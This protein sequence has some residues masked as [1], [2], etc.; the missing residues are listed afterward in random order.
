MH[1]VQDGPEACLD[2]RRAFEVS[3]AFHSRDDVQV[4]KAM[5]ATPTAVK[6]YPSSYIFVINMPGL[7]S[8]DIKVQ[9]LETLILQ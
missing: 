3:E 4:A 6:E 5:A 2:V 7:N 9:V 8:G 1:L